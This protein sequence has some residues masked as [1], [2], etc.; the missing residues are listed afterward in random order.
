MKTALNGSLAPLRLSV[1]TGSDGRCGQ[2]AKTEFEDR[3]GPHHV[4]LRT[5]TT[6][7]KK[8][9]RLFIVE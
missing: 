7:D 9:K 6:V 4:S 3:D 5:R 1:L 8:F 2:D